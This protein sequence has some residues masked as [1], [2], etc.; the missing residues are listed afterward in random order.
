MEEKDNNVAK[1]V[2][3]GKKD[4][5]IVAKKMVK[6]SVEISSMANFG[7]DLASS[8]T[9]QSEKPKKHAKTKSLNQVKGALSSYAFGS[10]NTEDF[11]F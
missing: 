3:E 8:E 6:K 4:G 9:I 1:T 5:E 10:F 7:G 2:K 11:P